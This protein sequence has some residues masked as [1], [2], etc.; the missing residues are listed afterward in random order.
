LPVESY[1]ST[2]KVTGSGEASTVEWTSTFDPK[3]M[4]EDE[5]KNVMSSVYAAGLDG[6]KGKF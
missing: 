6:L 3:G 5:A 4:P 1:V 2:I